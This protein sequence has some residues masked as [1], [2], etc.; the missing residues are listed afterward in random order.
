M[1]P[2]FFRSFYACRMVAYWQAYAKAGGFPQN[3]CR[4]V[5]EH[6]TVEMYILRVILHIPARNS[7]DRQRLY[8]LCLGTGVVSATVIWSCVQKRPVPEQAGT[9]DADLNRNGPSTLLRVQQA[10]SAAFKA[11]QL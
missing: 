4:D 7:A 10:L 2:A 11:V 1:P 5:L 9:F 8:R 6:V 3:V